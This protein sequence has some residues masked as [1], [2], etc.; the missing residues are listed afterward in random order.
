MGKSFY[1]V[2]AGRDGCGRVRRLALASEDN[3]RRR[4]DVGLSLD[5]RHLAL[6]GRA[7]G[8]SGLEWQRPTAHRERG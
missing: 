8:G 3:L 5:T 1:C 7:Q 2:P 6:G 4:W